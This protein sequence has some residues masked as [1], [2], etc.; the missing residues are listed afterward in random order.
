MVDPDRTDAQVRGGRALI[1]EVEGLGVRIW[2][3]AA[4]WGAFS[5]QELAVT[6]NGAE[7]TFAPERLIL[8]TG[9]YER[10]VPVSG[11]TLPGCMTTGAAQTLVRAYRVLPGRRVLVAGNGPLNLQLAAEL[12]AAGVDV[13]AVVEAATRPG[14]RHAGALL[15]AVSVAPGLMRDGFRYLARLRRAGVPVVYASALVAAHGDARV[16]GCTIARIDAAGRPVPGT[17]TRVAVDTVCVGHGFLPSN[18]IARALGCR[19]VVRGDSGDLATVTDSAGLTS[20]P[21]VLPSAMRSRSAART[22]RSVRASSPD[23][24]L[25]GRSA[26]R[27]RFRSRRSARG[28]S[29]NCAGMA[30][31][32][33]V[34]AI[35]RGPRVAQPVGSGGHDRLPL[36]GCPL[37]DDRWR[38]AR[39]RRERSARS[40]GARAP[41]W[42]AVRDVTANRSSPRCC[43]TNRT[44]CATSCSISHRVSQ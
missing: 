25:R 26:C 8:A 32:A 34:V 21:G 40:S 20:V 16:D 7:H 35:V 3:D 4:V 18:E 27:C 29:D 33:S 11:W 30:R 43:P 31:S 24:Q 44:R 42:V 37:R 5:A 28:A 1:D 13:V 22:P 14:L 15:R 17:S 39:R 9:A 36:R 19:H 10:G 38:A 23:A 12:V 41:A 6:A 2:R